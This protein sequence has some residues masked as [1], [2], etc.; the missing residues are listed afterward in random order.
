[1]KV[2]IYGG[3]TAMQSIKNTEKAQT[4]YNNEKLHSLLQV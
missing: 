3:G 1:M 4:F 2:I